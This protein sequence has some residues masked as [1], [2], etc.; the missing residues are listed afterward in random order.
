MASILVVDDDEGVRRVLH[1]ILSKSGHEVLEAADGAHAL[2]LCRESLPELALID[3]YM[4][5]QDGIETMRFLRKE[6]PHLKV[7]AMSG[8]Q[9]EV[10][11]GVL[12]MASMLGAVGVLRKPFEINEVI[13]AVNAALGEGG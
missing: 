1:R 4:P 5:G 2:T 13:E 3:M 12:Q 7:I 11:V 9:L 6:A 8:E 10:S